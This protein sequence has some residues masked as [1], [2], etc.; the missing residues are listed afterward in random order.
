MK[1][2][3]DDKVYP[4]FSASKTLHNARIS[5]KKIEEHKSESNKY[6][7]STAGSLYAI[8]CK[9]SSCPKSFDGLSASIRAILVS[10]NVF[11]KIM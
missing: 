7:P 6:S 4:L 1:V 10:Y 3:Q 5:T 9:D 8:R 2:F 11:I